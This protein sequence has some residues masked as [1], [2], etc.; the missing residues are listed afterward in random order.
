M[1]V[2]KKPQ[3]LD[4]VPKRGRRP[5][6]SALGRLIE[7]EFSLGG[8]LGSRGVDLL[9]AIQSLGSINRAAKAVG[10]SY[11]GAWEML[12]RMNTLSPRPL[13]ESAPGGTQG[14][15]TRLTVTGSAL[16]RAFASIRIEH[17]QFIDRINQEYAAE[18]IL[19]QWVRALYLRSTARNQ[20]QGWIT[21]IQKDGLSARVRV[22]V[23]GEQSIDVLITQHS[24]DRL[25]I[26]KGDE[27]VLL[28]KAPSVTIVD[29][30]EESIFFGQNALSGLVSR[31]HAG[32]VTSE[33][34]LSLPSGLH[35]VG[36]LAAEICTRWGIEPGQK[37]V[38][39]FDPESVIL[40]VRESAP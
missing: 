2:L 4:E 28:V 19:Q 36:T 13:I 40:A 35:V 15:G 6:P 17:E 24:L 12:E 9:L 32:S 23:R 22:D 29:S 11:K 38:A 1:P 8:C 20:W 25:A 10:L 7:G 18:P 39:V 16:V 5:E 21:S 34:T 14:G 33:V 31:V 30:L 37:A 27:V 26:R 3:V